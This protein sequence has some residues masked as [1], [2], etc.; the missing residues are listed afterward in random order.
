MEYLPG[1][2]RNPGMNGS[3][4]AARV[5]V[6]VFVILVRDRRF[7]NGEEMKCYS[8]DDQHSSSLDQSVE[9]TR[10]ETALVVHCSSLDA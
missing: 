4:P 8:P 10:L 3:H 1:K 2:L 7:T 9:H 6:R 5:I